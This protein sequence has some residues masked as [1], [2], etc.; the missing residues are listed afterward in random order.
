MR[1]V[2]VSASTK[3]CPIAA[4][5]VRSQSALSKGQQSATHMST[6]EQMA[7]KVAT[8][9]GGLT[10]LLSGTNPEVCE[11]ALPALA[12]LERALP[13]P[14]WD[15]NFLK[16]RY[17]VKDRRTIERMVERGELPPFIERG[18]SLLFRK[19]DV[20]ARERQDQIGEGHAAAMKAA[21]GGKGKVS[22]LR[23]DSA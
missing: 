13:V 22:F 5:R 16:R 15:H 21:L 11:D 12:A 2:R 19:A 23:K 14:F 8:A 17:G 9:A 10:E 1:C 6:T 4:G 18:S 20:L 3:G 7:N